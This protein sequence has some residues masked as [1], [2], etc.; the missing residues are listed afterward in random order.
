[1]GADTEVYRP[2]ATE[3]VFNTFRRKPLRPFYSLREFQIGVLIVIFL[4][5]LLVWVMK[6]GAHPDETLFTVPQNLLTDR[7]K[8]ITVYKR[9]VEPWVE[10][11]Q[12][13][14]ATSSPRLDP[15]PDAVASVDWRVASP[16]QMFDESNLY[17]KIDGRE[18][19]YKSYGFKKLHFLSLA[20]TE[21][22]G[23]TIDIELFDLG[24]IENALGALAAEISDPTTEVQMEPSGLSYTT[25]NAAFLSQ[26][27]YYARIMGSDDNQLIH[28][29]V[30]VLRDVLQG[31]LPGDTVPWSYALF[32]GRLHL[33]PARIQYDAENAFSFG[34]A[35]QVYS[36]GLTGS[37]TELFIAH[38]ASSA[39]A[40]ALAAKFAEGFAG[41]GKKLSASP[42]TA[43]VQ[44][45]Y[46]SAI[47]GVRAHGSFVIGVRQAKSAQEATQ[48]LD[49]LAAELD[50]GGITPKNDARTTNTTT[51]YHE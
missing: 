1:M 44:N 18:A 17:V 42:E 35:S 30:S 25:R 40:N 28:K 8:A 37:D 13:G 19:F 27:R 3:P 47:D 38:R 4:G 23:L 32:V 10:P 31:S 50:K 48:W 33:N 34:F 11:G 14:A 29:E 12:T 24:S 26:G 16:P 39:E 21:Q 43:F 49:R 2:P 5:G 15:F 41:F 22:D 36:A 9:P 45:E 7:G 20:S 6:R 51:A 46:T